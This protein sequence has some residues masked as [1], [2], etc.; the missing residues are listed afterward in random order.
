M[1]SFKINRLRQTSGSRGQLQFW[2]RFVR[3]TKEFGE[4]LEYI[5][6]NPVSKGL[7][8]KPEHWRWSSDNNFSLDKSI[9]ANCPIQVGYV[10]LPDS[11]RA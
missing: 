2:D 4:R 6:M 7:I 10:R 5:D 9:V 8:E 3:D 1:S 11:Y